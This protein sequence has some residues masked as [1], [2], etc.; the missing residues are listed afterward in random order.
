[1]IDF[2]ISDISAG[3]GVSFYVSEIDKKLYSSGKGSIN[4]HKKD[5]FIPEV[6]KS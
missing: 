3:F 2:P 4:G 5:V 1:M 6:V